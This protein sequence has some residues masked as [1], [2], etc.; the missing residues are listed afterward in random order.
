MNT[1]NELSMKIYWY[2]A[3]ENL[4]TH[5]RNLSELSEQLNL[6]KI[7]IRDYMFNRLDTSFVHIEGN[8]L[9]IAGFVTET[10]F[11]MLFNEY[12]QLKTVKAD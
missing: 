2:G 10:T 6:T 1:S 12:K 9:K 8:T 5:I 7:E 3:R 11:N 4:V